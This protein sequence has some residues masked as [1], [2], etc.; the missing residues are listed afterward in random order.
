RRGDTKANRFLH[1]I[2]KAR[3]NAAE[4]ALD[5]EKEIT[6]ELEKQERI[7]QG[8]AGQGAAALVAFNSRA[9]VYEAADRTVTEA[10]RK[11]AGGGQDYTRRMADDIHAIRNNTRQPAA[12]Y[13]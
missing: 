10:H 9:G 1:F 6:R 2:N 7:H 13:A 3:I 5:T 8:E 12:R 4:R 11:Q